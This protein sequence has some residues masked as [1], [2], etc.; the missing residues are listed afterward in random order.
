MLQFKNQIC[1]N[2]L[3]GRRGDFAIKK[4]YSQDIVCNHPGYEAI[5]D[6]ER[7]KE[8]AATSSTL[9]QP[10]ESDIEENPDQ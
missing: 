7:I 8:E 3:D 4:G 5:E 1:S 6:D 9:K 2:T 10:H